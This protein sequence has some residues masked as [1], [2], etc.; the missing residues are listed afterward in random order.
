MGK[1][2]VKEIFCGSPSEFGIMA[3]EFGTDYSTDDGGVGLNSINLNVD[4]NPVRVILWDKACGKGVAWVVAQSLPDKRSHIV[5]KVDND[6]DWAHLKKHW[7]NLWAE[8]V[9]QGWVKVQPKPTETSAESHKID[10]VD[11]A[12]IIEIRAIT[13]SQ[14][15]LTKL[16][17][18]CDELNK[19]YNNQSYFAVAMLTRAILDHIPPILECKSF[20]EV[21]NN[22]KGN[23]S[24]KEA[25][26]HLENSSRKIADTFLHGQIRNK[27]TLP[28]KTQVNFSS[29]LDLLLSEVVR[30]LK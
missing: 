2:V 22:Y 11:Q 23:K 12:R 18:L 4:A 6:D 9:L 15:D 28:N 13:T 21:S 3:R 20:S 14:F 30:L 10:F 16:I 24:F 29:D 26:Q 27:E 25:M 7:E 19:C 5:V 1:T 17:V 8:V